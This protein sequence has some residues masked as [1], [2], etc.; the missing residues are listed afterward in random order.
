M[1]AQIYHIDGLQLNHQMKVMSVSKYINNCL[2][3]VSGSY[4]GSYTLDKQN[5]LRSELVSFSAH[6]LK[7]VFPLDKNALFHIEVF[8]DNDKKISL[9]EIACRIGGNGINDEVRLQQGIDIKMEYIE[10]EC[11]LINSIKEV[12]PFHHPIAGR[13]LIPP[14]AGRLLSF[15]E[16][17]DMPGVVKYQFRGKKGSDYKKMQMSNDEIANF[18]IVSSNE[19]EMCEKI[20]QLSRWFDESVIWDR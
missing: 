5:P 7:D 4:L 12:Q 3:F 6:L 15:P 9:C 19:N 8:V 2:S 11:G 18:L 14:R 13:L 1:D 17:C 20:S 16:R 10:A